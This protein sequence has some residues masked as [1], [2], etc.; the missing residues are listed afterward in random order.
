MRAS[1]D[2]S[3]AAAQAYRNN[4]SAVVSE[5]TAIMAVKSTDKNERWVLLWGMEKDTPKKGKPDSACCRRPGAS[6]QPA[7]PI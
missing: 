4:Y 2:S 3:V 1:R 5:V 7:K 6:T